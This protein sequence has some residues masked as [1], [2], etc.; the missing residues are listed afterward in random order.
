[1]LASCRQGLDLRQT[2]CSGTKRHH[3]ATFGIAR[4]TLRTL[5]HLGIQPS[6]SGVKLDKHQQVLPMHNDAMSSE[7]PRHGRIDSNH[8]AQLAYNVCALQT[9]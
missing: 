2:Q 5:T 1:M 9:T 6:E 4:S 7:A 8:K 3:S